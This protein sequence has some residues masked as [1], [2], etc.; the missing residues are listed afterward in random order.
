MG[1]HRTIQDEQLLQYAREVFLKN[2]GFGSTKEI[3][4]RAGVSEATL[5]QRY[6]T[7]AELFLAAMIPQDVDIDDI[8]RSF[9]NDAD[10][11]QVLTEI[12]HRI[13]GYFRTLIPVIMHL[14]T[15]P[16]ISMADVTHHFKSM[17][18]HDTAGEQ[19]RAAIARALANDPPILVADE[20]TGNLDSKTTGAIQRLFA[21][22]VKKGKTVI[23]VTHENI[24]DF[25]YGRI[26]SLSDGAVVS[27]RKN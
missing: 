13:L 27:D 23:V 15:H 1:R 21:D 12:G 10:P 11:R 7:K 8:I 20:P 2:G 5:F 24:S 16:L 14:I 6:P 3:A 25:E 18:A 26:I 9:A 4:R 22:L 17:P 19:Q